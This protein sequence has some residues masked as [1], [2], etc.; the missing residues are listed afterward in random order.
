M[1]CTPDPLD[2]GPD[3][4]V[5]ETHSRLSRED[6]GVLAGDALLLNEE[7]RRCQP[8]PREVSARTGLAKGSIREA[9]GF[10]AAGVS[11][12]SRG[13]PERSLFAFRR[14]RG[15]TLLGRSFDFGCR[16]GW[17]FRRK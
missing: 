5:V 10:I 4:E 15:N 6:V 9:V 13:T 1:D 2:Q 7:L 11:C 14:K 3:F 16:G 8:S 17:R 12:S